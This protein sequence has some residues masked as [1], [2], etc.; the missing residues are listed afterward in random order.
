MKIN[1]VPQRRD[2]TLTLSLTG[3]SL[4]INGDAL[5][6]SAI[7][8]GATLPRDAVE[9]EW[10]ASDIE[11]DEEGELSLSLILPHGFIADPSTD[12]AKAVLFPDPITVAE[13][14]TITLPSYEATGATDD[15]NG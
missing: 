2:D 15:N 10:L 4:S 5:D 3:D 12:A 11:R 13:A 7:P 6:L 1:L 9:C 14:G 8:A